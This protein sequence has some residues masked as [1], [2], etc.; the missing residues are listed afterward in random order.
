MNLILAYIVQ[1]VIHIC[2]VLGALL[3]LAKVI[4]G[5]NNICKKKSVMIWKTRK[6][7]MATNTPQYSFLHQ[8]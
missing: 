2:G 1:S 6:F 3:C 4:H 8:Y 7:K 5:G